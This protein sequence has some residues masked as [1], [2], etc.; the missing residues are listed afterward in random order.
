MSVAPLPANP[1]GLDPELLDLHARVRAR[2]GDLAQAPPT[3]KLG[4]QRIRARDR[5]SKSSIRVDAAAVQKAQVELERARFNGADP[6][7]THPPDYA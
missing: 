7:E 6:D 2:M 4:R 3:S 5:L 1:H